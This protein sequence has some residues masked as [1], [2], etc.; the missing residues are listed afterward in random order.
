M[1]DSERAVRDNG[2]DRE[3]F[4]LEVGGLNVEFATP[5]GPVSALDDVGFRVGR[6]RILGLVGESGCGKSLSALSIMR[7]LPASARITGG[8]IRLA[9]AGDLLA[10]P[11]ARMRSLRGGRISMIFQ[12]PMT[13]LNPVMRI[14]AQMVEGMRYHQRI[15]RKE[16]RERAVEVLGMVGIK[17]PEKR[18]DDYPHQLS[19]GM[20]QRVMIGMA[21]ACEPQVML[22]DEPTTALDVSIQA[23]ILALMHEMRDRTG[24]AIVLI[25]HDLGVIAEMTDEVCVMYAGTVVERASVGRLFDSPL[26]PYTRGLMRSVRAGHDESLV[27]QALPAIP[28]NVPSLARLPTGCRFSDRCDRA[29]ADCHRIRPSLKEVDQ[30][31]EVRCLLYESDRAETDADTADRARPETEG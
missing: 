3:P 21:L 27:K 1:Y 4:A 2:A 18:V 29:F 10:L 30:G 14:G 23:Q 25:T 20:C 16:A 6:G 8:S 17:Q 19:G 11:E 9:G 7:L 13:S 5:W 15:G 24:T 28:G 22:A 12:D 31:H 26:H